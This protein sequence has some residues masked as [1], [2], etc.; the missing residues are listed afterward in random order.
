MSVVNFVKPTP[1][2]IKFIADNMR[3]EDVVEVYATANMDPH[4]ALMIEHHGAADYRTIGTADGIPVAIFGLTVHNPL[5]RLGVPWMLSATQILDYKKDILRYSPQV[6]DNM[7]DICPKLLNYV[8]TEN[9]LS[10]RWLKWLGFKIED[11]V[12]YGVNGELFHPF[13]QERN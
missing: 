3:P 5:T 10:I 11:P 4:E 7:L 12:P 9:K 13:H 1:E 6:V 8:H 2:A